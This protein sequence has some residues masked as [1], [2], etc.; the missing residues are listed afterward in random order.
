MKNRFSLNNLKIN[1]K[2]KHINALLEARRPLEMDIDGPAPQ[3]SKPIEVGKSKRFSSLFDEPKETQEET[4]EKIKSNILK[5]KQFAGTHP[6]GGQNNVLQVLYAGDINGEQTSVSN[7]NFCIIYTN[8]PLKVSSAYARTATPQ[9]G[10]GY[11]LIYNGT[12]YTID[13]GAN[14]SILPD[15][16]NKKLYQ[17]FLKNTGGPNSQVALDMITADGVLPTSARTNSLLQVSYNRDNP[18]SPKISSKPLSGDAFN[19][20]KAIISPYKD[21]GLGLASHLVDKYSADAGGTYVPHRGSAAYNEKKKRFGQLSIIIGNLNDLNAKLSRREFPEEGINGMDYDQFHS[22]L[23]KLE[24]EYDDLKNDLGEGE[25]R[26]EKVWVDKG[27]ALL[28]SK[29]T[30]GVDFGSTKSSTTPIVTKPSLDITD[31]SPPE[32]EPESSMDI[33]DLL[34]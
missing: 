28:G 33:D 21:G 3:S 4:P 6:G 27:F 24:K 22:Y 19:I 34:I 18:S 9:F 16:I 30:S 1:F 13:D 26:P 31:A 10:N 5:A 7:C 17:Y 29:F 32:K 23:S 2:T 11:V 15:K 14:N 8:P 20:I 12:L 25:T